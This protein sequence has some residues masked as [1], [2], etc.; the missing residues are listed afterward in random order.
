MTVIREATHTARFLKNARSIQV[1][2]TATESRSLLLALGCAAAVSM[3]YSTLRSR[4][5][6]P[7]DE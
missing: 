7:N 1:E 3:Y 6:C 5:M 4:K 2:G